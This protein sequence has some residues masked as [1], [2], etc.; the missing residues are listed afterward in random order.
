MRRRSQP[1]RLQQRMVHFPLGTWAALLIAI[2]MTVAVAAVGH[3]EPAAF[4]VVIVGLLVWRLFRR[5]RTRRNLARTAAVSP[6]LPRDRPERAPVGAGA[7]RGR[8]AEVV[9]QR[10]GGAEAGTPG[11][12]V[13]RQIGLLEQPA[14]L[15]HALGEQPLQRRRPG[16]LAKAA[17]EGAR[18][19]ARRGAPSRRR[20]VARR[21]VLR[22]RRR[23]G[24]SDP[25]V[26]APPAGGRRT[27]PGRPRGAAARPSSGRPRRRRRRR[28][29]SGSRA[30][31]GRGRR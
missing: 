7:G 21:G 28:S 26:A 14:G 6:D 20:R 25:R 23:V 29:P 19:D 16:L 2:A 15:E 3:L 5:H 12:L 17:G 10:S 11:D 30:G 24:S 13:D 9:A 4:G 22:P 1:A 27:G 8:P 31:P 18:A